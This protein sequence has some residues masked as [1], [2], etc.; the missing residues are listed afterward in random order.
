MNFGYML[1]NFALAVRADGTYTPFSADAWSYA[2]QMT[3]LGVGMVFS[4]LVALM[5]VLEIFKLIFIL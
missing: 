1:N 3:I 2:A 5:V 4:V